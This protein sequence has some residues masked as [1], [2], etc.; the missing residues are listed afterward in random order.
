MLDR[1]ALLIV[2]VVC[3]VLASVSWRYAGTWALDAFAIA[4]LVAYA[5]GNFRQRRK[6]RV[7]GIE[8]ARIDGLKRLMRGLL[9]MRDNR[10]ET[11]PAP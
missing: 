9:A 3:A 7:E 4:A 6:L 1:F 8:R 10:K 2:G 5:I 11:P